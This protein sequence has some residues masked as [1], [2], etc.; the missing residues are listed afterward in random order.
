MG[1]FL[2]GLSAFLFIFLMGFPAHSLECGKLL[3][4][5]IS[6]DS[7]MGEVTVFEEALASRKTDLPT[8]ESKINNVINI[9]NFYYDVGTKI[10]QTDP[11][12]IFEIDF[13]SSKFSEV[14]KRRYGKAVE[15]VESVLV[16]L[17]K[18]RGIQFTQNKNSI[19]ISQNGNHYMNQVARR[20][21]EQG[22]LK[23]SFNINNLLRYTA[24]GIFFDGLNSEINLPPKILREK[25][26]FQEDIVRHEFTHYKDFSEINN[27]D[28]YRPYHARINIKVLNQSTVALV[29][30]YRKGFSVD[31]IKAYRT[32]L[33]HYAHEA[34]TAKSKS[35]FS[36]SYKKFQRYLNMEIEFSRITK[37]VFGKYLQDLK[38]NK[39][40]KPNTV[41]LPGVAEFSFQ[42]KA[43]KPENAQLTLDMANFTF[44]MFNIMKDELHKHEKS[45]FEEQR[46]ALQKINSILS[47]PEVRKLQGNYPSIPSLKEVFQD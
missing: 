7:F 1:V 13:M 21:Y 15:G 29:G 45:S 30:V 24:G 20:L 43:G 23:L 38:A 34:L 5:P 31:E 3:S 46:A 12:N 22:R 40:E 11:D 32:S 19:V 27:S 16:D 4:Q 26:M 18:E 10:R 8:A 37:M 33:R 2:K 9:I 25:S 17:L 36:E 39:I 44:K 35:S 6:F 14:N 47:K 42:S 28:V 41:I